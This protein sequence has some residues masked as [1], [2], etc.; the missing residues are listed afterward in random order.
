M[1]NLTVEALANPALS[2]SKNAARKLILLMQKENTESVAMLKLA[3]KK[4]VADVAVSVG[5]TYEKRGHSSRT[6]AVF[7]LSIDTGE[8]LVYVIKCLLCHESSIHRKW[9][10]DSKNE[11]IKAGGTSTKPPVTLIIVDLQKEWKHKVPL[12]CFDVLLT[13]MFTIHNLCR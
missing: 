12:K 6:V 13:K 7:I 9:D 1:W 11:N 10:N 5:G 2:S 4:I 3:D 8:V